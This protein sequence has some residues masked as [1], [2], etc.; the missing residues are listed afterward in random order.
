MEYLPAYHVTVVI[1]TNAEWI[2]PVSA[3]ATIGKVALGG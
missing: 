1:L 2:D 3:A